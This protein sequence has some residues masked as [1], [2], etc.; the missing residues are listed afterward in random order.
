WQNIKLFL[1]QGGTVISVGSLPI[2]NI[3]GE[4]YERHEMYKVFDA[5]SLK[6][7]QNGMESKKLDYT[8]G[9]HNAFFIPINKESNT[10]KYLTTLNELIK[11]KLSSFIQFET[12]EQKKDFL[13]QHRFLSESESIV[14]ISNQ[15][16]RAQKTYL[17]ISNEK[18]NYECHGID[19]N[20]GEFYDIPIKQTA[21]EAKL[22]LNFSAYESMLIKLRKLDEKNEI[23]SSNKSIDCLQLDASG[24]WDVKPL[25]DNAIRF[26]HFDFTCGNEVQDK[27][28]E[29]KVKPFMNQYFEIDEIENTSLK[30]EQDFGITPKV[31]FSYTLK[32]SYKKE[33]NILQIPYNC[34]IMKDKLAILG[35]FEIKINGYCITENDFKFEYVYD[36]SNQVCDVQKFLKKGT[37]IIEINVIIKN[38]WEG[39]VDAIFLVGPFGVYFDENMT[40]LSKQNEKSHLKNG[41]YHGY[42]YYAGTFNFQKTVNLKE[43][44]SGERFNLEFLN[45]DAN[46]HDSA[47]VKINGNTLG[48]CSWSPYR[49][50][51]ETKILQSGY[52]NVEVEVTNTL[53]GLLEGKYFD[54][55]SHTLKDVRHI[56]K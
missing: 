35:D 18:E 15:E 54:Y 6:D 51:G 26:D 41:P 40:V 50:E 21:S 28:K 45:W 16:Y 7:Y 3:N 17:T 23:D 2:E 32:C 31:S 44:P 43:I 24:L 8:K 20:T 5:D 33:F 52:N 55:D 38:D 27:G 56:E 34:K 42:P 12:E 53:I 13:L 10:E 49:W 14:F 46:F 36:S 48:C 30:F 4:K 1:E 19:L 39:L 29:V 25:Q 47:V 22:M 37:N 11:S 9:K